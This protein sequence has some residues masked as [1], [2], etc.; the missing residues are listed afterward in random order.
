MLANIFG[1]EQRRC[2]LRLDF[3]LAVVSLNRSVAFVVDLDAE[4]PL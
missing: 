2:M 3:G 4:T 1:S